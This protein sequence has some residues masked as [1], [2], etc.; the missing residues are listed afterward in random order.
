MS[1]NEQTKHWYYTVKAMNDALESRQ[2][3]AVFL[4]TNYQ[5][6]KNG[7]YNWKKGFEPKDEKAVL[8]LLNADLMSH[9]I[10]NIES[11]LALARV[12]ILA[13]KK[14]INHEKMN[15]WYFSKNMKEI[16]SFSKIIG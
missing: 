14:G 11:L 15:K 7:K 16:A 5:N 4:T 12:G 10:R 2:K 3:Y 13:Q 9:V 8:R 6:I 1:F